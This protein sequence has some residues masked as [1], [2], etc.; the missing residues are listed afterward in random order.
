MERQVEWKQIPVYVGRRHAHN[1]QKPQSLTHQTG[2]KQKRAVLYVPV[3]ETEETL[4]KNNSKRAYQLAKDLT[5]EKEEKATTVQDRSGNCI[6]EE[7]QI[8]NRCIEY[9]SE[10]YN[11]KAN[12]DPSVLYWPPTHWGWP[13]H[14]SQKSEG[15]STITEGREVS[16]SCQH[17]SIAGSS[18]GEDVITALMTICNKIWQTGE[19]PTPWT[20]SLVITLPKKRQPAVVP[21]LPKYQPH[22]PSRQSHAEDHDWSHKWRRSSL[23]NWQASEQEGAP[24]RRS[25]TYGSCTRNISSTSKTSTM[26]S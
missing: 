2:R 23:K 7:R 16:W 3:S 14:P 12:G 15:C 9:C 4:R 19:W 6:T 22:Q 25:L 24:Q 20:Q 17:P 13:T 11:H 10:L 1:Q 21:E 8:P 5:T 18:G 26:S